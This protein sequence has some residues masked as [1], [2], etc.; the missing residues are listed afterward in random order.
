[1]TIKAIFIFLTLVIGLLG[2]SGFK[3]IKTLKEEL[4][5]SQLTNETQS[6][7]IE[8]LQVYVQNLSQYFTNK[9]HQHTDYAEENHSHY[10]YSQDGHKHDYADE[11]HSH[12]RYADKEEFEMLRNNFRTLESSFNLHQYNTSKHHRH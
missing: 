3:Q 2:F 12:S 5:A 7:S 9:N 4:A 6:K 1:M 8:R 10:D 11:Y